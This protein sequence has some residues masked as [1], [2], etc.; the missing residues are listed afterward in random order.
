DR[1]PL[2]TNLLD[3]KEDMSIKFQPDYYYAGE[4][5]EGEL[6]NTEC[7]YIIDCKENAEMIYGHTASSKKELVTMINSG[8]W[9]GL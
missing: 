5:V 9:E 7:C 3:V 4:N 1:F 8:D 2:L 6:G